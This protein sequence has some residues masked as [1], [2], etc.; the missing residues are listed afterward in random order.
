MEKLIA[1]APTVAERVLDK[2]IH[3]EPN[4]VLPN[5]RKAT[6]VTYDFEFLDIEPDKQ[7]NDLFFAPANMVCF[8]VYNSLFQLFSSTTLF[9]GIGLSKSWS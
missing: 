6:K 7:V 8:A 9:T 1:V 3:T 4:H 5:G 2:C